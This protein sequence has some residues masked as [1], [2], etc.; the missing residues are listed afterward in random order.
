MQSKA[1]KHW[2]VMLISAM[3]VQQNPYT[4]QSQMHPSLSKAS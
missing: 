4:S 2:E 3:T 1:M